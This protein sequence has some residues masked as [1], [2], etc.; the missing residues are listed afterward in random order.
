[1]NTKYLILLLVL[2]FVLPSCQERPQ[3]RVTMDDSQLK[4]S[5]EKAN[6]YLSNEEEED[7]KNYMER[8]Q[9]TAISTGTGMRYQII[10][11]GTGEAVVPGKT[12]TIEY[13]LQ[14]IMGDVV[15]S[16]E[17]EGNMT[18][19][20][21][22]GDVVPGLDEAMKYLH[23]GDVAKVIV[24]SHLGYGLVGDQKSIPGLATLIYTVKVVE[25]KN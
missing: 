4:G 5:L 25:V 7:I 8:H 2:A 24:P 1:M 13:V 12:V 18:F 15:Y 21:G 16:S 3:Q 19:V 20:V 9:M 14:N 23:Q 11:N 22:C 17:Q 10:R 6:R